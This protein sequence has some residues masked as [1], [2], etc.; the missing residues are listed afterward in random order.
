MG[1]FR[2]IAVAGVLVVI[3]IVGVV[4]YTVFKP[5]LE[6]SGP[7]K[8]IPLS[9]TTGAASVATT[10]PAAPTPAPTEVPAAT[11]ASATTT[12]ATTVS[13]TAVPATSET[14]VAATTEATVAATTEATAAAEPA[15]TASPAASA[16]TAASSPILAQ[17]D[18]S[19]SEA[20]FAINEVLSGSPNK[21]IGKTNQVAGELSVDP[22]DPSKSRIGTIQVDARTLATDSTFRNRSIK[23][24]IL[25]TD[26]NEFIT[27]TPTS[28]VG[29]PTQPATTGTS[30]TFKIVGDHHSWDDQGSHI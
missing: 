8:A 21:V 9:A 28:L 18:Q 2:R 10:A 19:Q 6:A 23:N 4:A 17:I 5:P 20:R 22:S 25:L 11:T 3:V 24:R 26:A 13:E 30:Y 12:I 29:L 14:A 7:L 27:F 1:N 16:T 15:V